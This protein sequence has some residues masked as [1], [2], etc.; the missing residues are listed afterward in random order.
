MNGWD[1]SG[2][3]RGFVHQQ[4][5]NNRANGISGFCTMTILQVVDTH[6]WGTGFDLYCCD[7][8]FMVNGLLSKQAHW[9]MKKT[10]CPLS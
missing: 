8:D 5:K 9:C 2:S 3:K 7:F 10:E 6:V 1:Q 4:A